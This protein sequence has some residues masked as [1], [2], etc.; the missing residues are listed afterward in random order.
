MP[1][2]EDHGAKG[3]MEKTL[4]LY[5]DAA[6]EIGRRG[7]RVDPMLF[8]SQSGLTKAKRRGLW[9]KGWHSGFGS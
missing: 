1:E 5:S 2:E 6:R 9:G 4:L 3:M 7:A 8:Q